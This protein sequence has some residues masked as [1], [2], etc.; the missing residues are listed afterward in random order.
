MSDIFVSYANEDLDRIRPLLRAL[1]QTGWSV[2]WDRTIP[3][4]AT[5]R[6]AIGTEIDNCRCMIVVWSQHSVDSDWVHEEADEGKRR[7][8][9]APVLIDHILPPMGFR[10]IQSAKLADWD[11][12]APSTEFDRLLADLSNI[13]GIAPAKA[14]EQQRQVEREASHKA[15]Q[16][17]R[18]K[19]QAEQQQRVEEEAKRKAEEAAAQERERAV[20]EAEQQQASQRKAKQETQR[21]Q[22]EQ[23]ARRKAAQVA[24]SKPTE[25]PPITHDTPNGSRPMTNKLIV[26]AGI[27]LAIIVVTVIIS[28]SQHEPVPDPVTPPLVSPSEA[29][30]EAKRRAEEEAIR[31]A[32]QATASKTAEVHREREQKLA[33]LLTQGAAAEQARRLTTPEHDNA[34]G[35]Y[36]DALALDPG[37]PDARAGLKR[38]TEQYIAWAEQAQAQR[39][40]VKAEDYL[41]KAR[42]VDPGHP[43]LRHFVADLEAAS[44]PAPD[45]QLTAGKAFRDRLK[46]GSEGPEMVVIPAGTFRMGDIQGVG[47]KD[48][49]PVHHVKIARPFALMV[50]ELTVGEFEKFVKQTNYKIQAESGTGCYIWTGSVWKIDTARSWRNPGFPQSARQP[51]VCVNWDDAVAYAEW[52]SAQTGKRYRL[53]S[54]AEWEYAVRA[55]EPSAYWWGDEMKEGMANCKGCDGRWGGK[56]TSP[57]GSFTAN[58]FGLFDTAGNVWEWTQDCW[59][60]KYENAPDDGRA[61]EKGAGGDCGLRV[62]RGGSWYSEP[63]YLRSSFRFRNFTGSRSYNVGFRLAQDLEQ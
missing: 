39:R 45:R 38:V 23:A 20:K 21:K 10:S 49:K 24:A 51:V 37:N 4:G 7:G 19:A 28:L 41:A 14:E 2:F 26:P 36:R 29:Q 17:S 13:L 54:E 9:L 40:F 32:E 16:E 50:T 33:D 8:V 56:Q 58:P 44:P 47:N 5:W 35:Y 27:A 43:A 1:E 30:Q 52:L 55:N 12:N 60:K 25:P 15:E 42:S 53:P 22:D 62:L 6:Q 31:K 3:V 11:G 61:W 48:E 18:R 34:V 63:R 57:V 46:D 59:H